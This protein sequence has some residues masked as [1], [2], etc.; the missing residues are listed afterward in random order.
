MKERFVRDIQTGDTVADVFLLTAKQMLTKRDGN[1]YLRLVLSDRTGTIP[2]V[3]WDGIGEETQDLEAGILVEITGKASA[4]QGQV[5][6]TVQ[7]IRRCDP[8]GI[9]PSGFLPQTR[10]DID[11]MF[12]RLMVL[13][14]SVQSE[15]IRTLLKAV[16]E[17]ETFARDFRRAPAAKH[18]HHAYLGG[19]LE[20]TLSVSLLADR[21]ASHYAGI[22]RDLLLAGA[23][24]HDIGKVFELD[25]QH[26]IDYTDEGRL[27]SHIVLGLRLLDQKVS[28][29]PD[30]DPE[31]LML[32]RHLV[33]SHH[34]QREFGSPEEPKTIEA[35]ILNHVDD[36]DAKVT[37]V[38]ELMYSTDP[39]E[40]WTAW[41]RLLE[42]QF[43][44]GLQD[45]NIA[46]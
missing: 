23:L 21:V 37:A 1:P 35:L 3:M 38:R 25:F 43:Y 26:T 24:L 14:D 33:V 28:G 46:G 4:Y 39:K 29:I 17:D 11:K 6:L 16:F 18:M 31:R 8:T 27:L 15:W 42:R 12:E 36:I 9:D 19:L 13:I 20:H 41:H 22:D 32:L 7:R 44:M 45:S 40:R 5:Q 2:A 30:I 34:G 10:K